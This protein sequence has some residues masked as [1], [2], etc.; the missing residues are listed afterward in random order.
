[1]RLPAAEINAL[2]RL[3]HRGPV[4]ARPPVRV[5]ADV[6]VWLR[7]ARDHAAWSG[8]RTGLAERRTGSGTRSAS[9]EKPGAPEASEGVDLPG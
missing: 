3:R 6:L 4:T 9:Q 7:R 1:M 8:P 2:S 5:P